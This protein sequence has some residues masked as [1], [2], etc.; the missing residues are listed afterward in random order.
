MLHRKARI[1]AA[2]PLEMPGQPAAGLKDDQK[3]RFPFRRRGIRQQA[4]GLRHRSLSGQGQGRAV[5]SGPRRRQGTHGAGIHVVPDGF[6]Q[7][8]YHH[9]PVVNGFPHFGN[10]VSLKEYAALGRGQHQRV[11]QLFQNF[12]VIGDAL[13]GHHFL[14]KAAFHAAQAGKR[15]DLDV[16]RV[17]H[18]RELFG[19]KRHP[20]PSLARRLFRFSVNLLFLL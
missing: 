8:L 4:E 7:P 11:R 9:P 15:R 12:G 19:K 1:P 5:Q 16:G 2:V 13:A 18:L 6:Q 14:N 17:D 10:A 20:N 3:L